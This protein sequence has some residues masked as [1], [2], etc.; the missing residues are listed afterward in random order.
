MG[1]LFW[2]ENPKILFE[3]SRLIQFFPTKDQTYKE[4]YNSLAR[5]FIYTG[6]LLFLYK[7]KP[8]AL[9]IIIFGLAFTMLLNS[10]IK[11]EIPAEYPEVV[12]SE[13]KCVR[14]TKDNPFM[15]F[16]LNDFS[17]NPAKKTACDYDSTLPGG[18]TVKETLENTF[19]TDI[20]KN[21]SDVFNKDNS[22]RQFYTMPSTTWPNDQTTYSN[23]LY[24]T[25]EPTCKED[26][27]FCY[28]N[29][30]EYGNDLRR[31]SNRFFVKE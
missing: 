12:I 21:V 2:T 8:W 29:M 16:L 7:G 6:I 4:R 18:E 31:S 9:Y 23:W 17:D 3:K 22:Q 24:N 15:N 28:K 14:P 19:N 26:T 5:L 10:S 27:E 11:K 1:D 30:G 25:G 20:Y 13:D